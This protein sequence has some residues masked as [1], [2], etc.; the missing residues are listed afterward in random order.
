[1]PQ[2]TEPWHLDKRVPIALIVTLL[3]QTAGVVW[4]AAGLE[5]RVSEHQ[6]RIVT[7][8]NFDAQS[9]AEARRVSELLARLDERLNTQTE[10]LREI[11]E[12]LG[13]EAR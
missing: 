12:R 9:S 5:Y 10:L 13:R 2:P 1:M 6:R 4:W 3:A 11:R 7:L 8:E